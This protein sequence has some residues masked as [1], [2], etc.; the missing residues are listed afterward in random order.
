M[1]IL[2]FGDGA[3]ATDSLKALIKEGHDLLG[4]V[5]RKVPT[6]P[7]LLELGQEKNIQLFRPDKVNDPDFVAHMGGLEP[8]INLSVS[9][10]QIFK[11]DLIQT[12]SLGF[13]NF[14]AGQLPFYRGR[15]VINWAIINGETT[16]G[17]TAHFV[18]SGIDT[19]DIVLQRLL[20]LDWTDTYGDALQKVVRAFPALV[21]DTVRAF[22]EG[23][24]PRKVQASEL[25]TYFPLRR[26]GDEWLDWSDTSRNLYNKIRGI[27]RPGPGSQTLLG[28]Q[29]VKIWRASYDPSWPSY[30]A[31]PGHVVNRC[32]EKG[33]TVKTGDSTIVLHEVQI[34]G[35]LPCVPT[36]PLGT[37]LGLDVVCHLHQ[38]QYR[39]E[40]S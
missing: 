26:D 33:V 5:I 1:R 22:T 31:T 13:V 34:G 30:L 38:M 21:T 37:R 16:I 32:S 9:F 8:E 14:H 15:N 35:D 40:G 2:F 28:P 6:D 23:Q 4:L 36:W 18:D 19:G 29:L 10:D 11:S 39:L 20:P 25:G 24:V 27:S 3:W 7:N 12:P 17:L